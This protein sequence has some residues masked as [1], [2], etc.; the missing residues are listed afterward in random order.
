MLKIYSGLFCLDNQSINAQSIHFLKS[1]LQ[2][3]LLRISLYSKLP[4]ITDT[5]SLTFW[6]YWHKQTE[7]IP[8]WLT[9]FTHLG[10]SSLNF[11]NPIL[12]DGYSFL[13][14]RNNCLVFNR[15]KNFWC[16]VLILSFVTDTKS[17]IP[18]QHLEYSSFW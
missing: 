11:E 3:T 9:V 7:W 15:S 1:I 2:T 8:L 13:N 10:L 5:N 18:G 16:F 17:F 14:S 6:W 4:G 12:T